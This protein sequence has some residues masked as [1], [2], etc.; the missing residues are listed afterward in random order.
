MCDSG[1]PYFENC[2]NCPTDCG[3]CPAGGVDTDIDGVPNN[4]EKPGCDNTPDCD[5]DGAPDYYDLCPNTNGALFRLVNGK[6]SANGCLAGD[7]SNS[8]GDRIQPDGCFDDKDVAFQLQIYGE[9]QNR[10]AC[11]IRQ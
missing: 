6:V 11:L 5:S 8:A 3:A 9:S 1:A 7:L 2:G 10:Q 4:Q